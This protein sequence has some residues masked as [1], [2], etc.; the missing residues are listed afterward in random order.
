MKERLA[1][2][3][4]RASAGG[5][6]RPRAFRPIL[7]LALGT[8]TSFLGAQASENRL[9]G[10]VLSPPPT[11]DGVV[12]AT[13]EWGGAP[14]GEG[15]FDAETGVPASE[16]GQFWLAYDA[17][18]VYFAA[19]LRDPN[20]Q[21]IQAV[22]YRTNVGLGSD[23][24]VSLVLD[25]FGSLAE[26]NT[27]SINPRGATSLQIAG[28]R[29]LK[30]EWLGEIVARAR[31]TQDGWEV[32]ARIPWKLMRLPAPGSRDMRFN[33]RRYQSRNQRSVNWRYSR[34][35]RIRDIGVW[36]GVETPRIPVERAIKLLP[37]AYLGA[38]EDEATIANG[39]LDFKAKLSETVDLAGTVNPDF[40]N[41]E[42]DVLSL[43]FSYFERVAGE[44]RPF[45]LEGRG[46]YDTGSSSRLFLSQRIRSFDAGVKAF[47]R[48]DGRTSFGL[49]NLSDFGKRNV[50][51]ASVGHEF[52]PR[53]SV[54]AAFVGNAERGR[55]NDAARIGAFHGFGKWG[56]F[57]GSQHTRDAARGDG[58]ERTAGL[59]FEDQRFGMSAEYVETSP[60]YFPRIGFARERNRRGVNVQAGVTET[61]R[62]GIFSEIDF[63][64]FAYEYRRLNGDPYRRGAG[65]DISLTTTSAL[66]IDLEV[67]SQRFRG[68][69]DVTYSISIEKPR[70]DVNRRWELTYSWGR[71]AG[72]NRYQDISAIFAYR[73]VKR[74]QTFLSIQRFRLFETETQAI[75]GANYDLGGD[76]AFSSRAVVRENDVNWY[77][78]Y[79]RS[80][81]FGA[82]YFVILGDPNADRFRPSLVVKAV[83]PLEI[84]F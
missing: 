9:P 37:Y 11:I 5:R 21:S 77:L 8:L 20:P 1:P 74:L 24:S 43:D 40:R 51:V 25:P 78:S 60:D 4:R 46:F 50:F 84:R 7:V 61:P 79:R 10:V 56:A 26:F 68:N 28:G 44:T 58:Y 36:A 42:N 32:E 67:E 39:G 75:I 81:G 53:T 70:R 14:S 66:D 57:V 16:G 27:F 82:E 29:A 54:G 52:G 49:M 18:Y 65:V 62:K 22:E 12:D 71:L 34:G 31:I 64:A 55:A 23:D 19:R 41:V 30:R 33:V 17:S 2:E 63:S 80:G 6:G 47:G 59:N 72:S 13:A 73:P 35:E 69:D 38:A 3:S 45:F 48:L 76:Q 83:F 15:F